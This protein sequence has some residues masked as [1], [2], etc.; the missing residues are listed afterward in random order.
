MKDFKANG[1]RQPSIPVKGV[2][3]RSQ[4]WYLAELV[5][6]CRVAGK[7]TSLVW[8]NTHCLKAKSAAEAY[9]KAVTL[10][11]AHNSSYKNIHQKPVTWR[12][13]G[14][15]ELLPIYEKIADGAE[16]FYETHTRLTSSGVRKMLIKKQVLCAFREEK[17]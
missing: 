11:K 6:E 15:R 14:L 9:R 2:R 1:T 16:L 7:S 8:I 12:F 4:G 5:Q 3:G 10:G 17:R 13:R